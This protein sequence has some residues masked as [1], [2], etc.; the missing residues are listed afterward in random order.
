VT[1]PRDTTIGAPLSAVEQTVLRWTAAGY[2]NPAIAEAIG[3]AVDT[4]K[5]HLRRVSVKLG[6]R[7]RTHSV[8]LAIAA[9]DLVLADSGRVTICSRQGC[10]GPAHGL[11]CLQLASA[12]VRPTG[13]TR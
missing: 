3:V 9:G 8:V 6:S 12:V 4:V 7:D 10:D 5:T 13:S 1:Q 11:R 2:S